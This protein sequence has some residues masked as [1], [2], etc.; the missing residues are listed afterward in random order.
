MKRLLL[1]FSFAFIFLGFNAHP[2]EITQHMTGSWYNPDQ[3]GHGFNIEV[4]SESKS[5]F[6]W[7][8]Y[9]P[10]GTPMWLV[11][12]GPHN[13][14]RIEGVAYY[15]TGM[16]WGVFDPSEREDQERWGT[17][18][19][20]FVGCN[21]ATVN[22]Q[23]DDP[24]EQAI[25]YG[26]G[27]FNMVR[28]TYVH[29]SKCSEVPHAGIYT[30]TFWSETREE[31]YPGTVLLDTQGGFFG[32]VTDYK[33]F[34]ASHSVIGKDIFVDGWAYSNDTGEIQYPATTMEGRIVEDYRLF[35]AY[36]APGPEEGFAD[37][38]PVTQLYFR[39]VTLAG[40][41]GDY[42]AEDLHTFDEGTASIGTDG[43][44]TGTDAA[45]CHWS[46]QIS[47]P[48]VEFNMFDITLTVSEC[49]EKDGYYEGKGFE[50]DAEDLEDG[51]A[52]WFFAFGGER[53]LSANL[54]RIIP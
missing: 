48:D 25:P 8:V 3:D 44:I 27:S 40:L 19:I 29:K 54:T 37:L 16:R 21:S 36:D 45:S 38:Y 1:L 4:L 17:V 23:S 28:L 35:A 24:S 32:Y 43:V 5:V 53:S 22:Y 46:G 51:M 30:G 47:I 39:G 6:Y 11:G 18:T 50:G 12:A 42:E 52:V 31:G 20:D 34:H 10:D 7:Y 33:S 13:E 41:A 14:G 15:N 9:N 26:S 49:G 2:I